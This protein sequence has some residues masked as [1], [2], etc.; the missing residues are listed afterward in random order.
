MIIVTAGGPQ[1]PTALLRQL[2]IG[3]RLIIPVGDTPRLQ[4]LVRVTRTA[5]DKFEDE[6]L[7]GVQFVPLIGA[8]G[9][10]PS[11]IKSER[12][13]ARGRSSSVAKLIRES[14]EPIDRIDT[15]DIDSLLDRIGNAR[16]VLLGEATQRNLR[17]LSDAGAHHE[18]IDPA[19]RV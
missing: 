6:D 11:L 15:A 8:E 18:G 1:L 13:S 17:I 4:R 14:A 10:E 2:A 5:E 7:G 16:V 3:G 9:W 19:A 12:H